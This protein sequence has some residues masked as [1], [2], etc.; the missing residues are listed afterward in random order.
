MYLQMSTLKHYLTNYTFVL[1]ICGILKDLWFHYTM[2]YIKL[3]RSLKHLILNLR[4]SGINTFFL[5]LKASNV[6]ERV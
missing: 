1:Q 5:I 4:L 3:I 6:Q 2:L